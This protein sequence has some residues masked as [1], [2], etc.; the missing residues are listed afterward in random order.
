VTGNVTVGQGASLVVGLNSTINGSIY[1]NSCNFVELV[2]EGNEQVG[3]NVWI[4]NCTGNPSFLSTGTNSVIS[5]SFE[6]LFNSGPCVLEIATVGGGVQ[7]LYNVGPSPS[8]F[9][10]NHISNN[11]QCEGN[12]PSPSGDSNNVGGTMQGQCTGF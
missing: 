4:I 12:S 6:C 10:Y 7:V 5:G 1:A 2:S 8:K 11:L 9:E 3:G